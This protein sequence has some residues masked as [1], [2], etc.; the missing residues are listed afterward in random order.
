MIQWQGL[1]HRYIQTSPL[2]NKWTICQFRVSWPI[3]ESNTK[4]ASIVLANRL[5]ISIKAIMYKGEKNGDKHKP[6]KKGFYFSLDDPH[7][8]VHFGWD[9]VDLKLIREFSLSIPNYSTKSWLKTGNVYRKSLFTCILP[10]F[11][12]SWVLRTNPLDSPL[13]PCNKS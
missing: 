3:N 1:W 10:I 6:P 11:H 9:A 12:P 8:I 5:V 13:H 2:T 4:I 7:L